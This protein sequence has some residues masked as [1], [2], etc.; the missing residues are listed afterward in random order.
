MSNEMQTVPTLASLF[1]VASTLTEADRLAHGANSVY[2]TK[3]ISV[4]VNDPITGETRRGSKTGAEFLTE[5][6]GTLA[7]KRRTGKVLPVAPV[8]AL[9][10]SFTAK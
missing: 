2:S 9:L 5:T 10:D 6:L 8:Q 3:R 7:E 1:A 4:P